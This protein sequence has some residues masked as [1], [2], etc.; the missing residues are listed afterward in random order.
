[1]SWGYYLCNLCNDWSVNRGYGCSERFRSWKGDLIWS[2][3][4]IYTCNDWNV[5]Q[6][7]IFPKGP[8]SWTGDII[9]LWYVQ[10]LEWKP[11]N[12]CPKDLPGISCTGD[13][14]CLICAT[15]GTQTRDVSFPNY[16]DRKLGVWSG[17]ICATIGTKLREICLLRII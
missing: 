9:C 8:R 4:L 17:L 2:I 5:N 14:I 11:G 15:I 3:C 6:G 12:S 16:L 1:M 13:M 10:I 7:F